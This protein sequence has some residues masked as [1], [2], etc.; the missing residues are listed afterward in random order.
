VISTVDIVSQEKVGSV[1]KLSAF[2]KKFEQVKELAMYI[3][4]NLN[5]KRNMLDIALLNQELGDEVTECEHLV[6]RYALI[7]LKLLNS[8]QSITLRHRLN[9]K[10]IINWNI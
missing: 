7:P 8:F 2:L 1:W 6:F 10:I 5:R 4:T 9:D 3:S